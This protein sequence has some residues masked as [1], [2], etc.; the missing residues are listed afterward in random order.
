M[1]FVSR[2]NFFTQAHD[3]DVGNNFGHRGSGT[4]HLLLRLQGH[5]LLQKNWYTVFKTMADSGQ[6]GTS[7]FPS[8][9]D[10]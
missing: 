7:N 2:N 8:E 5:E 9:N 4:K 3:G 10:D 1:N 6:Y